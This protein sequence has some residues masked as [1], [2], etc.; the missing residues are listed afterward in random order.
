MK[1]KSKKPKIMTADQ[2]QQ[3]QWAAG[4]ADKHLDDL[5]WQ[6][7]FRGGDIKV[8]DSIRKS[9]NLLESATGAAAKLFA[10]QFDKP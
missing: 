8:T 7:V 3:L 9:R 2:L 6:V 4:L 10:A 5:H 1:E